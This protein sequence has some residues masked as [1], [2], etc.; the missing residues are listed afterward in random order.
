MSFEKDK[1]Y[2]KYVDDKIKEMDALIAEL[3]ELEAYYENPVKPELLDS[4]F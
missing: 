2:L 3:E 1:E 4:V